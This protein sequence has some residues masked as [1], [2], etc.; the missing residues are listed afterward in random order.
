MVY[1]QAGWGGYSS[2]TVISG[3][4]PMSK[5]EPKEGLRR[6]TGT[7]A[8]KK[9]RPYVAPELTLESDALGSEAGKGHFASEPTPQ[10]G[11]TS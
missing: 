5:I 9:R 2:V 8:P 11:R 3:G 1:G 6:E 4:I 10:L 7:A